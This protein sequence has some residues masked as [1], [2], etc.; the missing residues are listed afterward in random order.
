MLIEIAALIIEKRNQCK[1]VT[2]NSNLPNLLVTIPNEATL[3]RVS[4][5]DNETSLLS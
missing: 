2:V 1:T 5:R 4:G 3:R